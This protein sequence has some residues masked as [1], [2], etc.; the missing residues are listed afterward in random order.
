M[1]VRGPDQGYAWRDIRHI[2][3]PWAQSDTLA[4]TSSTGYATWQ[5]RAL[6]K[7]AGLHWFQ[8][9]FDDLSWTE[10]EALPNPGET[11][12]GIGLRWKDLFFWQQRGLS[13]QT[14]QGMHL[15]WDEIDSCTVHWAG[16]DVVWTQ[17]PGA[18]PPTG[19]LEEDNS[20]LSW[21]VIEH[22]PQDDNT[23]LGYTLPAGLMPTDKQR[24]RLQLTAQPAIAGA[25]PL[26]LPAAGRYIWTLDD[27]TLLAQKG[28]A[29]TLQ[30][31]AQYV[32]SFENVGFALV[33]DA[34]VLALDDFEMAVAAIDGTPLDAGVQL[35]HQKPGRLIFECARGIPP[36]DQWSGLVALVHMRALRSA[37]TTVSLLRVNTGLLRVV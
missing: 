13:W 4:G 14:L 24:A 28:E 3:A 34:A 33:Y 15:R 20:W 16:N 27:E 26:L 6:M 30:L 8:I 23:H 35:L 22:L 19:P 36:A 37:K 32:R 7:P 11:P 9:H 5:D 21:D 31:D 17:R 29:F 2:G 1:P 25:E 10:F 18:M 12:A